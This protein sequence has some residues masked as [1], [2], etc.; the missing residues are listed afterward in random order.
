V[1]LINIAFTA[2]DD[3]DAIPDRITVEMSLAEATA[4]VTIFG[5]MNTFAMRKLDIGD[6]DGL[7]GIY[8]CLT[9]SVFN[10][11]WDGGQSDLLRFDSS[12]LDALN[13]RNQT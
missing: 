4:I 11:Y 13:E 9:G 12:L 1:K 5:A 10:R 8:G 7:D 3:G 6:P 2:D